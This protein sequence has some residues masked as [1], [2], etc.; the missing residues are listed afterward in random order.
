MGLI[1]YIL[2]SALLTSNR[3]SPVYD[4]IEMIA[5]IISLT[6]TASA[7]RARGQHR[8]IAASSEGIHICISLL[9]NIFDA[10]TFSQRAHSALSRKY[11]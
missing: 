10:T 6:V 9:I 3:I 8:R 5:C 11:A 7:R 4:A 2:S 1:G